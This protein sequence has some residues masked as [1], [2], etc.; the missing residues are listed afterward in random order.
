L[1]DGSTTDFRFLAEHSLDVLCRADLERKFVYVS[2]SCVHV[3]GWDAAEMVGR[4][5][6]EFIY[7]EDRV[8]LAGAVGKERHT[9]VFRMKKKDG[10]L[11][12]MENT[13]QLVRDD[14]TKEPI[15]WI[16]TMRDISERKALEEQLR[17]LAT[18]D[19]LTGLTNRRAF[20]E[21]LNREWSRTLWEG[22]DLS[23]L[24][25]DIDHFKRFNDRFGHQVGD[26][27]LRAVSIAVRKS[28]RRSDMVARY[29]GE[30]L[31]VILAGAD[32]ENSARVAEKIRVA[33]EELDLKLGDRD[34]AECRVTVSIGAA[35]AIARQG[36]TMRMP[37]SLLLAADNAL[38]QAKR[39]GR[40]RIATAL[41][42]ASKD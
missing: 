33:V 17:E 5:A 23:L 26:D 40:N 35:T 32:M 31:A 34:D 38:Y 2:P 22:G 36:G 11:A 24:L 6:I 4:A 18:V 20:D 15:E 28:V 30:E 1:A 37:E 39:E 19:G 42:M 3:L 27:C 21:A 9:V 41:L 12:W 16:V 7:E 8:L 14:E 25:L 29:G 10:S 13:A